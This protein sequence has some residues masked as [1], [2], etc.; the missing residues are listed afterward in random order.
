MHTECIPVEFEHLAQ[1]FRKPTWQLQI[2]GSEQ[3][4]TVLNLQI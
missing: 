2:I 1:M 3:Y 4:F